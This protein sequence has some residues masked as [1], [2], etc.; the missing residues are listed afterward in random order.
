MQLQVQQSA[1]QAELR[2]K[3][4]KL[5][6]HPDTKNI[7]E[8]L[9]TLGEIILQ[10]EIKE[11]PESTRLL[12]SNNAMG[13]H[14]D[15][16]AANYIAWFC[17]SQSAIGGESILL[18]TRKLLDQLSNTSQQL[19]SEI[20][21][22][23][24]QVFHDDKISHPLLTILENEAQVYYASWLVNQPFFK[25]HQNILHRFEELIASATPTKLL[26]SEGD[27]LIIDNHKML[28]G[29]QGFTK[30]SNRWLTRFW[31]KK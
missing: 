25:E 9:S 26:L 17:N 6:K 16:P 20:T 11:N 3:G 12:A 5:I 23:T 30:N 27:V 2:V 31:I 18:D 8:I 29:R 15:H 7:Q 13:F 1:L 28:H 4:F 10:T 14:T 21:L 22:K 24:H 19:L